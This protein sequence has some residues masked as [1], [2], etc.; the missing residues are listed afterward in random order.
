MQESRVI[1]FLK[2]TDTQQKKKKKANK[3][4]LTIACALAWLFL[5]VNVRWLSNLCG[6]NG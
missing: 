5:F 1:Y 2:A 6:L 4:G 3:K